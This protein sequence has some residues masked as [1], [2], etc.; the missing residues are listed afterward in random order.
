MT[1]IPDRAARVDDVVNGVPIY[2]PRDFVTG[3]AGWI[4]M[5]PESVD[6]R[7]P[8]IMARLVSRWCD[9]QNLWDCSDNYPQN[10]RDYPES[11]EVDFDGNR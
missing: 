2:R 7:D 4:S 5:A 8:S 3:F 11:Y 9:S 1:F 6:L 10:L